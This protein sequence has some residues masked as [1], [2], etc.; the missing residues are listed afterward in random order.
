M[1]SLE[2]RVPPVPLAALFAA[3]MYGV[4]SV[5]PAAT[6]L[7]PGRKTIAIVLAAIALAI[8]A[9]CSSLGGL[10]GSEDPIQWLLEQPINRGTRMTNCDR[11][12]NPTLA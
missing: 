5:T 4:S 12:A 1:Q 11:R 2:L 10:P 9:S 6:F 7:I 3:A 8:V